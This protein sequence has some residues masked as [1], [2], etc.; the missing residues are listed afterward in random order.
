VS[1]RRVAALLFICTGASALIAEQAFEKLLEP[2]LGTTVHAAAAVLS[3]YFA[4]LTLGGWLYRFVRRTRPLRT[5]ALLELG[6]GAWALMLYIGFEQLT[7]IFLPLLRTAADN[8]AALE[9]MR[10][11][12]ASLWILPPAVLMG[13]TFPAMVDFIAG[14]RRGVTRFYALNLLGATIAAVAAPYALFATIGLDKGLLVA[15][16]I[17]LAAGIVAWRSDRG[18]EPPAM[19]APQDDRGEPKVRFLT[20]AAFTSGLLFFALEVI[21]T[22]LIATVCGNSVYAFAAM[23]FSVLAGLFLG[24]VIASRLAQGSDSLPATVPAF[25][26]TTGAALLALQQMAWPHVPHLF[27]MLGPGVQSF[28]AAETLRTLIAFALVAPAAAVLGSVLPMLFR[29]REFPLAEQ[30]RSAGVMTAANA[31]GCCA[32]A[33]LAAFVFIPAVG[34]EASLLAIAIVYA[35]AGAAVVL[36]AAPR[37]RAAGLATALVTLL[38]AAAAPHW[39]RLKLTSGEN[40]YFA[41]AFARPGSRLLFFHEDAAG[42][43]TTVVDNNRTRILLTNGKFQGNDSGET[44]AQR[45]F[46]LVP[47]VH[48]SRFD[49]ALV[50]GLGT[51]NSAGIVHR[52]GFRRIDIAEIAPGI[53]AAAREWFPHVNGRVLEEPNVRTILEDGRNVLELRDHRYDL[54]TMEITSMWFA[55]ATNLYSRDFYRAAAAR[56]QPHGVIQQWL[57]LHHLSGR[58]VVSVIA[59]MRSVF[60]YVTFWIVGGQGIV[61]GTMEPQTLRAEA[62]ARGIAAAGAWE[63]RLVL[64]DRVL[65]EDDVT[66]MVASMN[67]TVNSDRNRWLE[68]HSPRYNLRRDDFASINARA[69]RSFARPAP[70]RAEPQAAALL[71]TIR[72]ASQPR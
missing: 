45:G 6:V 34:S 29:L 31:I 23:L 19:A 20:A 9:T 69:L 71:Q 26:F 52:L 72:Q 37:H 39:D 5:Y 50:I 68:Y 56:L 12:V 57:Q 13:A 58:E 63:V 36:V 54:I 46:A 21:W 25:A 55:G 70:L 41:P 53:V 22:H 47:A 7:A 27:T 44:S 16:C 43:I 61:V 30:G 11:A 66:R 24:S 65:A 15:A 2:L 42:G 18:T 51:G 62:L 3:I 33:L 17:D 38:L 40:V 32:G 4:G 35:L 10:L 48:V 49:D 28:A 59:S 64:R 8:F 67:S 1:G 60:P 14:D